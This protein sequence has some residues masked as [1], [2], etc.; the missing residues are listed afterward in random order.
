MWEEKERQINRFGNG[1][2]RAHE[3]IQIEERIFTGSLMDQD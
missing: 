3:R 1:G 2:S